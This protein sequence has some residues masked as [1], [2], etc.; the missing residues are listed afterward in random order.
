MWKNFWFSWST[1]F[2]C[3]GILDLYPIL[4]QKNYF[5]LII[6]HISS[7]SILG[8]FRFFI[9]VPFTLSHCL[10]AS[11]NQRFKVAGCILKTSAVASLLI[12]FME[13][14]KAKSM[15]DSSLRRL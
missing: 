7:I 13:V 4:I 12:P 6:T 2:P 14:L 5:F 10:A 15:V 3:F 8:T 1:S 9:K 11:A